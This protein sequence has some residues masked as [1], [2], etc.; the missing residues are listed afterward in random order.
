MSKGQSAVEYLFNYS[1]MILVVSI[2]VVVLFAIIS[3]PRVQD[4][5]GFEDDLLLEGFGATS[6][7]TLQM[8]FRNLGNTD[9]DINWG[10]ITGNQNFTEVDAEEFILSSGESGIIEFQSVEQDQTTRTF[11][12]IVNY[13]RGVLEDIETIGTITAPME[14]T[15]TVVEVEFDSEW[16]LPAVERRVRAVEYYED[17]VYVLS[18]QDS[19]PSYIQAVSTENVDESGKAEE[20]WRLESS[21]A[22]DI[23]EARPLEFNPDDQL[24]YTAS[25]D[26]D[27]IQ[28]DPDE[29]KDVGEDYE[30]IDDSGVT[31]TDAVNDDIRDIE[32][33][34][35]YVYFGT[36]ANDEAAILRADAD[37][38]QDEGA[39]LK[40]PDDTDEFSEGIGKVTGLALGEENV[41]ASARDG[42][43]Y[44][45]D[46][47]LEPEWK[48]ENW[49]TGTDQWGIT[50]IDIDNDR[51]ILYTS[52]HGNHT[53]ALKLTDLDES[54]PESSWQDAE[55]WRYEGL[56]EGQKWGILADEDEEVVYAGDNDG[57][58]HRI[59]ETGGLNGNLTLRRP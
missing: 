7:G 10:N 31:I 48:L 14:I 4:S 44:A 2:T 24:V 15:D 23:D 59:N 43:V 38:I 29:S 11:D 21:V 19:P 20:Y 56:S 16:Y 27:I 54:N 30:V 51:N 34:E 13:D 52:A 5:T 42:T 32:F 39:W 58:L 18:Q 1:W 3:D 33:R 45:V 49:Q 37:N 50:S 22:Q 57:N 28:I 55:M 17:T 12:V 46:E 53:A 8:Q 26:G 25:A 40:N 6:E 35:N 36:E 9:I 41:Y 47:N